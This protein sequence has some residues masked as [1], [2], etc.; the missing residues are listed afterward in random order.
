M[1]L[2]MK[3][4]TDELELPLAVADSP[5]ELA[6]MLKANYGTIATMV[7]KQICGYHKVEIEDTEL[8]PDNDGNPWCYDNNGRVVIVEG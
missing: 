1:K 7:S 5:K 2:Y 4:T 6:V 8:Y 3:C